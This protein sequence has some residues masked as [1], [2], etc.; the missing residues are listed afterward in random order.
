[1]AIVIPSLLDQGAPATP[2]TIIERLLSVRGITD[3]AG[4][5]GAGPLHDPFLLSGMEQAVTLIESII[6]SGAL[7]VVYGDYDCD[8]VSATVLLYDY[9]T[10]RGANVAYYIPEREGEGYGLNLSACQLL[11]QNQAALVITVDNGISAVEEVAWLEA[12]GIPVVITDHHTPPETL[13]KASATINPHLSPGYPCRCLSGVGVAF[14]LL[15]AL[16]GDCDGVETL[17]RVGALVA[18]GTVA[19]IVPLVDENRTLVKAGLRLIEEEAHLG[20]SA[21]LSTAGDQRGPVCSSTITFLLAPRINAAAR[22]GSV[23]KAVELL[24]CEE[25]QEAAAIAEQ[26]ESTNRQRRECEGRIMQEILA[27]IESEPALSA[28]RVLAVSGDGWHQGV[29]GICAARLAE[30]YKKPCVL[31]S[32][33]EGEGCGSGRS[34]PGFSIIDAISAGGALLTKFGGHRGAAGMSLPRENISRFFQAIEQYAAAT[35]PEMPTPRVQADVAIHSACLDLSVARALL[36]LEPFGCQ[37]EAPRFLL[38]N[39]KVERIVPIGE[40]KHT[41][42][43]LGGCR[44][45][46][47]GKTANQFPVSA[48]Q[49]VDAVLTLSINQYMGE[50][51]LSVQVQEIWPHGL[52]AEQA[53]DEERLFLRL[54]EGAA[55]TPKEAG[56][57]CPNREQIAALYRQLRVGDWPGEESILYQRLHD[58]LPCSFGQLLVSVR[59]LLEAGLVA[60]EQDRLLVVPAKEKVDLF[61][62]KILTRLHALLK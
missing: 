62:T 29:I 46:C 6:Q 42:L 20:L 4:F 24:L 25:P 14:K 9:L 15:C 57:L 22:M 26:L 27:K 44:A 32:V 58:K 34:V 45:V 61:M 11:K 2:D 13:P 7:V 60:V 56:A 40:G 52:P 49:S 50:D 53:A 36:E 5:L 39:V 1:M 31:V 28:G 41:G 47:F 23:E 19:D 21:L 3:R 33:V 16:E 35:H 30:R 10:Q 38:Q 37:N 48:G 17:E 43:Q 12:A 51:R 59:A 54:L 8:G 18:L 55:L